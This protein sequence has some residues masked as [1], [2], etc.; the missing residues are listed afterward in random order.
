MKREK[1]RRQPDMLKIIVIID[2]DICGESFERIAV[3]TD[4]NPQT[5]GCL[6]LSLEADAEHCG[7]DCYSA[8]R[9]Y[10]C[11]PESARYPAS[12]DPSTESDF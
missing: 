7:W 6:P 9:C 2:C 12:A 8:H 1:Q 10:D 11:F 3:T 4:R 5:W